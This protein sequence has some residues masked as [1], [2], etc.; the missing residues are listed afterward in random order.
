MAIVTT[1]IMIPLTLIIVVPGVILEIL[2]IVVLVAISLLTFS[3]VLDPPSPIF[4][5][6][7]VPLFNG[8]LGGSH[9]RVK[10]EVF[11]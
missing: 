5:D 1:V 7:K 4:K 8:D 2:E 11:S 3:L 6:F 9:L 10:P